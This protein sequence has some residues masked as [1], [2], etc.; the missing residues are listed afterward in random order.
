MTLSEACNSSFCL[1]KEKKDTITYT[2][3]IQHNYYFQVQCQLYCSEKEWCHFVVR[4][5]RDIHVQ[6]IY[7]DRM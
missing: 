5:E 4:T 1:K 6:R 2:L 7:W 3:K